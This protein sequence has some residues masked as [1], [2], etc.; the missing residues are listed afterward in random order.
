MTIPPQLPLLSTPLP[1]PPPTGYEDLH[2]HG[3]SHESEPSTSST[4]PIT[5]LASPDS[6][7]APG[8]VTLGLNGL[9]GL[10]TATA[11]T[12]T[13]AANTVQMC[14]QWGFQGSV[15]LATG[16]SLLSYSPVS[17]RCYDGIRIVQ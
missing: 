10:D 6:V 7:I 11:T 9:F 12:T 2:G 8:S 15:Y 4:I 3:H 14:E 16:I 5:T 1:P 17:S 13:T